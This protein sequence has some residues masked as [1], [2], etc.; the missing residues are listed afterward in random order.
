MSWPDIVS[1]LDTY[2]APGFIPP[3]METIDPSNMSDGERAAL[4]ALICAAQN[5]PGSASFKFIL[6]SDVMPSTP[7]GI[8]VSPSP[9]HAS[10]SSDDGE[11]S[12]GYTSSLMQHEVSTSTAL[13]PDVELPSISA[14]GAAPPSVD[15]SGDYEHAED[16]TTAP[17]SSRE[18]NISAPAKPPRKRKDAN[19]DEPKGGPA[20]KKQ[21]TVEFVSSI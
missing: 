5:T 6:P 7:L 18:S 15:L 10:P 8:C 11:H 13:S 16:G 3:T 14:T 4:Y 21:R 12:D 20:S 2:V 17:V 1:D 9:T 19:R